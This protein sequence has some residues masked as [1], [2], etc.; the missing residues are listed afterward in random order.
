LD[1][2]NAKINSKVTNCLLDVSKVRYINSSGIGLLIT[3]VTKFRSH[4]GE[5]VLINPS[6]QVKKLITITKLDAIFKIVQNEKEALTY[7]KK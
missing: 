2:V 7:L 6:D 1:Q 3:L 5:V 4:N